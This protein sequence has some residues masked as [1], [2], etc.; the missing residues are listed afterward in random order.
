[1]LY[2]DKRDKRESSGKWMVG[3]GKSAEILV[4]SRTINPSEELD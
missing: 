3:G 1:M 4:F 2:N